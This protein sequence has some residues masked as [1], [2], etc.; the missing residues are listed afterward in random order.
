MRRIASGFIFFSLIIGGVLAISLL[1]DGTAYAGEPLPPPYP[2]DYACRG[3]H[4]ENQRTLALPSGE[5]LPLLAARE[6][7][8]ES[9]HNSSADQP[10]YCMSC[11]TNATNYRY[12][13]PPTDEETQRDH[14]QIHS[15]ECASCHYPHNPLHDEE[16]IDPAQPVCADCH[17]SHDVQPVATV[18]D[19]MPAS[20]IS[21]HDD[22]TLEW[23]TNFIAPRPGLG[24]GAPGYVGS[25]RCSSCHDQEYYAWRDT[26]HARMIQDPTVD[27]DAVVGDFDSNDPDRPFTLGDV[28][29]TIGG[30]WKQQYIRQDESGEL[31]ILP[32]QWIVESATWTT[33]L[34]ATAEI[35]ATFIITGPDGL[36]DWRRSCGSCH[37]TGLDTERW[38]FSEFGVG[39]ESCHGPGESHINDPE[40]V[41]LPA[42]DEQTCGACHSRGVSPEGHSFPAAYQPG[43][44]LSDHFTPST[45]ESDLWPDGSARRN[46]Q[47]YTDWDQGSRMA[48]SGDTSCTTCHAVHGEGVGEIQLVEPLN[49][50][51]LRCHSGKTAI[52]Q[53]TP[54]H[55]RANLEQ[56]FTCADCHMPEMA[57]SA[58]QYDIHNH[59]MLQP[60]PQASIDHGGAD[61]MPNSCNLCHT[62][63]GEDPQWAVET[64]DYVS[65]I[66]TPIPENA[67]NPGPTPTSPPPPTAIPSVGEPAPDVR[68]VEAWLWVRMAMYAMLGLIV[69]GGIYLIY[70]WVRSRGQ[71]SEEATDA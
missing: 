70:R 59:S 20:C 4:G 65:T 21:C 36:T 34:T 63:T 31:T 3:C 11:H 30:H 15:Q 43:D 55:D 58:V 68:N 13:H 1:L 44:T 12:P 6:F 9:V 47:Q 33:E 52:I 49:D 61:L 38:E 10:I 19:Q 7:L 35:S 62:R 28:A 54:Y 25:A 17:D 26:L 5:T 69:L 51:C 22:Q 16:M 50:L 46:H 29:Y 45:D 64:I 48:L 27:P 23:A 39:C 2:P 40:N 60:D 32:A 53:H 18:A 37:V 42:V 8:D 66:I 41:D 71:Q 24:E 56:D 57:T 67:F 14:T